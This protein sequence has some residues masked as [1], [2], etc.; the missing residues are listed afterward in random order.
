MLVIKKNCM[1]SLFN[2]QKDIIPVLENGQ[3][4]IDDSCWLLEIAS[5]FGVPTMLL[6]HKGLGET[7]KSVKDRSQNSFQSEV[8][9]FSMLKHENICHHVETQQK[10]QYLLAGAEPH[11]SLL[12][13]AVDLQALGKQVFILEDV[14]S[15]RNAEDIRVSIK[16]FEQLGCQML[17][18]EMLFFEL[19]RYSEYPNYIDLSMKF[20]DNRYY[21]E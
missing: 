11:I 19:L 14:I 13:T 10:D 17:T 3:K 18:K 4:L 2:V 16:R 21:R 5:T 12:Q 6:E 9:Y 20:L 1:I 15:S 8:I 7:V